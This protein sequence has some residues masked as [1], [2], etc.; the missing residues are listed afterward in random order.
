MKAG[1]AALFLGG[2][3]LVACGCGRSQRQDGPVGGAPDTAGANADLQA[4]LVHE[5]FAVLDYRAV[6]DEYGRVHVVGEVKNVSTAARGVELQ[7]TLRDALGRILAVGNFYPASNHNITPGETWPFTYSFGK[8]DQGVRAE[9]RI[10][11]A[12]RTIETLGVMTRP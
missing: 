4:R 10:I 12:F 8:Y 3:L 5:G 9:L 7:A 11:G 1:C 2:L 6:R